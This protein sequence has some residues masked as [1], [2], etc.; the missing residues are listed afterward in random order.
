MPDPK[1]WPKRFYVA[2]V[3]GEPAQVEGLRI[4]A[5]MPEQLPFEEA[6][7]KAKALSRRYQPV[8]VSHIDWLKEQGR[9]A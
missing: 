6:K 3:V 9:I 8:S 2:E 1:D 5:V 7:R 4:V